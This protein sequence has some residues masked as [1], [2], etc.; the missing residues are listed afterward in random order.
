M[1]LTLSRAIVLSMAL[2]DGRL[3]SI[4]A[5]RDP[6]AFSPFFLTILEHP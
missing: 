4:A 1:G 5:V 6:E 2:Y 3:I